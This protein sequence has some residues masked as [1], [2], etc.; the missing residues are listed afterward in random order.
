MLDNFGNEVYGCI[1]KLTCLMNNKCYIGQTA[2]FERRKKD[3][4]SKL[5]HQKANRYLQKDWNEYSEYNFEW[6]I[7]G[8][9]NSIEEIAETEAQ[10]KLF[11]NSLDRN[12]GYNILLYDIDYCKNPGS[13][14]KGKKLEEIFEIDKVIEWKENCRKASSGEN[15]GMYGRHHTEQ[16]CQQISD[17]RKQKELGKGK[18]NGRWKNIDEDLVRK[19]FLLGYSFKKIINE[20]NII[21]NETCGHSSIG[22]VLKKIKKEVIN[23]FFR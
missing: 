21:K 12:Y 3:H 18:N 20:Y 11:F 17:I 23:D 15:N 7:L 9:C 6:K 13:R 16:T 4:I 1:Y 14:R 19:L 2:N 5:S 10:C 22:R 8:Y